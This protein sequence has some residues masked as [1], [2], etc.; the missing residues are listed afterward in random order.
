MVRDATL[1]IDYFALEIDCASC[2]GSEVYIVVL[3]PF[4][5]HCTYVSFDVHCFDDVY[6]N[7]SSRLADEFLTEVLVD[8]IEEGRLT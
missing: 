5:T 7:D 3:D 8:S 1:D 2:R 4:L 6:V